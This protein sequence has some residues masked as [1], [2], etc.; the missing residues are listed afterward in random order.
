MV[1]TRGKNQPGPDGPRHR[2]RH[3]GRAEH[4]LAVGRPEPDLH[5]APV[6][7]GLPARVREQLRRQARSRPASCSVG[8]RLPAASRHGD[9]GDDQGAGGDHARP[10][11]SS[12]RTSLNIPMLAA[13]PYGNFIPGPLRGLP[14]Y[15]TATGLV[16]GN[17]AAPVPVPA[18]VRALRHA[19]PDRHRAQRRPAPTHRGR[20]GRRHHGRRARST[21][22]PAGRHLR[23]R[24]A[25]RALH[26][27]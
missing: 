22:R 6:A 24:A 14:Q 9:L 4:R 11:S 23:R 7:P 18:N 13:D 8:R 15:V 20:P 19:V 2:R 3:P 25:G 21:R 17:I 16:E 5:L 10:R 1:L 26:R 27:R 12:T